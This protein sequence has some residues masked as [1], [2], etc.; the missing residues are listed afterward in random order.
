MAQGYINWKDFAVKSRQSCVMSCLPEAYAGL[1][2]SLIHRLSALIWNNVFSLY[3][4]M[5]ASIFQMSLTCLLQSLI[6]RF[7]LIVE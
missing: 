7:D 6:R 1:S 2:M 5:R 3:C 4:W